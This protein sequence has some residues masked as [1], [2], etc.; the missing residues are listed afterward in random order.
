MLTLSTKA[1][2]MKSGLSLVDNGAASLLITWG[3]LLMLTFPAFAMESESVTVNALDLGPSA[4]DSA[5]IA[6]SDGIEI[7]TI[8]VTG[9]VLLDESKV[10]T[11][12]TIKAGDIIVGEFTS[13]PS[14]TG[15]TLWRSG[16]FPRP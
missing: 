4:G 15:T 7:R 13:M 16:S 11:G 8:N 12:L 5:V 9:L 6:A 14:V 2:N 3:L 10:L 1:E